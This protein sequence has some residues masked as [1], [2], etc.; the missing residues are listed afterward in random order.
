[1]AALA[2]TY[3][4]AGSPE[5]DAAVQGLWGLLNTVPSA[6]GAPEAAADGAVVWAPRSRSGT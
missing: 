3:R 5:A 4:E 1:M 2:P 6:G